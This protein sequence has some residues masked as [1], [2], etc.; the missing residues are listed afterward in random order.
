MCKSLVHFINF[1]TIFFCCDGFTWFYKPILNYT[2]WG[3]PNNHYKL[4]LME[5]R[6]SEVLWSLLC[7]QPLCWMFTVIVQNPLFITSHYS[8]EKRIILVVKKKGRRNFKTFAFMIPIQF[9]RNQ[10]IHFFKLCQSIL[11]YMKWL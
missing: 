9:M 5:F 4:F 6:L 11:D 3:P 2:S 7:I 10:L 8:I 1:Y